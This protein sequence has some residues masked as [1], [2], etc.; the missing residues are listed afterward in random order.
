MRGIKNLLLLLVVF[1]SLSSQAQLIPNF[2]GQRAGLSTL[3]FLK[4]DLALAANSDIRFVL[5]ESA[6]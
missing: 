2:G 5:G 1:G 3:A 6:N 4:N